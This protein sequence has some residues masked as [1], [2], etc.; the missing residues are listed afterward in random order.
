MGVS[1]NMQNNFVVRPSSEY[2]LLENIYIR[3]ILRKYILLEGYI[4]KG[5][6]IFHREQNRFDNE[7][8]SRLQLIYPYF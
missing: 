4:Y 6:G 7:D 5:K 2:I 3:E 1:T 8:F